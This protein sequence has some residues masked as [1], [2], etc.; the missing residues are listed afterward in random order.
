MLLHGDEDINT[1]DTSI[2]TL[3]QISGPDTQAHAHQLNY[4]VTSFLASC[5]SY[6]DSENMCSLLLL[7]NEGQEQNRDGFTQVRF[8]F[9]NNTKL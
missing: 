9:H 6:L 1:N 5:S 4:Q 2:P 3:K 8:G 7:R